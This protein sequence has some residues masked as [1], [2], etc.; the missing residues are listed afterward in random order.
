MK[1]LTYDG[2]GSSNV[3]AVR[4]IT[5]PRP[6]RGEVLVHV[7][8]AALNPKDVFIRRGRFRLVSG[9]RFPKIV[10]LDFAGEIVERG[11]GPPRGSEERQVFGFFDHWSALRGTVAEYVTAPAHQLA[12]IPRGCS[13]EEAAAVPLA[14][15]TALQALRD[16][17]HVRAGD[18]VYIHGASGGVGTFA[19]QIA[20]ALGA[21]VTTTSSAPSR[22][23]CSALGADDALD[24][25]AIGG[26]PRDRDFRVVLDV[27]GNLSLS[28][29]RSSLAA[30]GVYVTTVPSLRIFRDSAMTI[31]G[32]PRARL[33][34]VRPRAADLESLARLVEDG[35]LRPHIDRVFPLASAVDAVRH[36]ETWHAHG[37][38]VV[39]ID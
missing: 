38:V 24:Y 33:V 7:R 22:E 29:V 18:R 35:R 16:V 12:A 27:F 1:A 23:L 4:E 17:A 8:A 2:Y 25:A 37:K 9:S 32:S 14:G 13:F 15:S 30:D 5:A 6:Q 20:K 3:L 34:M 11:R 28:R 26:L 31:V 19:I 21:H 36:L 10:G 39:R